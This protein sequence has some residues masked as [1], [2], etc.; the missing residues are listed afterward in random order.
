MGSGS[1]TGGRREAHVHRIRDDR[2]EIKPRGHKWSLGFGFTERSHCNIESHVLA[3]VINPNLHRLS[4]DQLEPLDHAFLGVKVSRRRRVHRYQA[5]NIDPDMVVVDVL[6]LHVLDRVELH[7]D[8][9]VSGAAGVREEAEMLAGQ[10]PTE[11]LRGGEDKSNSMAA[12]LGESGFDGEHEG[13]REGR[14][15]TEAESEGVESVADHLLRVVRQTQEAFGGD[16]REAVEG[17]VRAAESVEG[18]VTIGGRR[19]LG[20]KDNSEDP[21]KKHGWCRTCNR[22]RVK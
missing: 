2:R 10:R 4:T 12:R 5:V 11:L 21:G 7:S 18:E 8:D 9:M 22:S 1:R 17:Q 19:E 20:E 14:R 3:T 16:R 6:K 15:L 13:A